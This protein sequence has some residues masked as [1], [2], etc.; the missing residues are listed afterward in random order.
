MN[1]PFYE[2]VQAFANADTKHEQRLVR[3]KDAAE[4]LSVSKKHLYSLAE[5]PDFPRHVQVGTRAVAWRMSDLEAWIDS[6]LHKKE[7][8]VK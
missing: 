3:P 6:R 2:L 7:E 1:T 8:V 4:M 5:H